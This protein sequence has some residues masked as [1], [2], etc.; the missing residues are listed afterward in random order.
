MLQRGNDLKTIDSDARDGALRFHKRDPERVIHHRYV[1]NSCFIILSRYH[2]LLLLFVYAAGETLTVTDADV[3][4][5][6]WEG[7]NSKGVK[8]IFPAS[9]KWL[10]M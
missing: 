4:N 9:C 2:Q 7:M 5:G 8:G 3:G 10:R 1:E 6:W